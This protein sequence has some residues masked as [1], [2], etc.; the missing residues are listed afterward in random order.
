MKRT[1]RNK[2]KGRNNAVEDSKRIFSRMANG[3]D[4]AG[5]R[6]FC[7]REKL[8]L[9]FLLAALFLSLLLG[10]YYVSPC[11]TSSEFGHDESYYMAMAQRLAEEHVYAYGDSASPNAFVPPGLPLY[12]CLCYC[13]FGFG[14]QGLAI[15][16][17]LQIGYTV[18]TV[19]LVYV[20][21]KQL[22]G[23]AWAGV[24][25][26]WMIA[27]NL[28][29]YAYTDTF[30]TE[31]LYFLFMMSFAVLYSHTLRR[32]NQGFFASGL[33]FCA[34]VMIRSAIAATLPL[35]LV[36]IFQKHREEKAQA[37]SRAGLFLLGFLLLALP[38]WIRNA[39]TLHEWIPF[40]KQ[41]HIV[42]LGFAEDMS[43]YPPPEGIRGHLRLLG[44]L[45]RTDLWGTLSWM[46]AGKFKIL[47]LQTG[48][49][50]NSRLYAVNT[51]TIVL[52]GMPVWIWRL[53][54]KRH[55][56]SSLCF[57]V[58]LLVVFCGVPDQ[59]YGLQFLFYLSIQAAALLVLVAQR[60]P[61]PLKMK[62][63]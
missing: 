26:A 18:L 55:C 59:R 20:F 28:S 34:C 30:L 45:L 23:S 63:G 53:F 14:P 51:I 39:V 19:F 47:F 49:S 1:F 7:S 41:K 40:C 58:Y 52:L 27:T 35:L 57:L 42:Y 3:S 4:D 46:T 8:C 33:L 16:R 22:T 31:N 25:A 2:S 32:D 50:L 6:R 21:G 37:F 56:L 36:P 38:W 44:E 10:I 29:F 5:R 43:S 15:M 17:I 24:L 48:T 9:Y 12:L 61:I 60:I 13:L 62:T 54:S 11:L